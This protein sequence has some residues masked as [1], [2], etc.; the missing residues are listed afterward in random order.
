MGTPLIECYLEPVNINSTPEYDV[1]SSAWGNPRQPT[2]GDIDQ[3]GTMHQYPI[4]V[5]GRI[6][7]VPRN[8]YE[9]LKMAKEV[10]D[11]IERRDELGKTELIRAAQENRIGA[12]RECL[13]QNAWIHAQDNFGETA[14]HYAAENGLLNIVE[15]LLNHGASMGIVDS[16]GRTPLD[17]CSLWNHKQW[18]LAEEL[19][20]EWSKS[21][22]DRELVPA[23]ECIRVGR[24]IWID[25]VCVNQS[26]PDEQTSHSAMMAQIYGGAQSIVAWLGVSD[27][28][29]RIARKAITALIGNT[30]DDAMSEDDAWL[31]KSD[32]SRQDSV[33]FDLLERSW[34]ERPCLFQEVALGRAITAYCGSYKFRLADLL[35]F[36]RMQQLENIPS[37]LN[38][39]S[40]MEEDKGGQMRYE[41][42][43]RLKGAEPEAMRSQHGSTL[44]D[45]TPGN[46]ALPHNHLR[47]I[48]ASSLTLF[49]Q[50]QLD[51][52][53]TFG[54]EQSP[55]RFISPSGD[56]Y[57]PVDFPTRRSPHQSLGHLPERIRVRSSFESFDTFLYQRWQT[58]PLDCLF[59]RH[60]KLRL[61][62]V[63]EI[64]PNMLNHVVLPAH[65]AATIPKLCLGGLAFLVVQFLLSTLYYLLFH[66]LRKFPGPPL[67]RVSRLWS[68]IGNFKGRKS[69]RIHEAHLKYG[70][71]VRVGPNELSFAD[72][73]AVREIYN[74]DV[75]IKE[76]TFYRAKRIFHEDFL[77]SY[78]DP[79]AHKQRRKL[80]SRGFSQAAMLD[81]EPH[82]NTKITA[83]LDHWAETAAPDQAF[84]VY[85]WVH[86]LGF[87][88]VYHL[89]FDEDPGSVKYGR[90][91]EVMPYFRAW[92]PTYIYKEFMPI[93]E[94]WGVIVPGPVGN[95]FRG[96]AM[97]II[98]NC[99][100]SEVN[101][102]FLRQVLHGAKDGYLGRALTNSEI[103][104]EC[105]GGM[106][107]GSGTTANT[108]VYI[109]WGCLRKPEVAK[110]LREELVAAFPDRD[111]IPDHR[112]CSGLPLL[113]AVINETLRRYPTIIAT[114]PRAATKDAVVRGVAIP[115]GTIVGVQNYTM[116]RNE[117]A[118]PNSE[119]W[120][121]KRWLTK[122][123]EELR[124]EAW[125]PFSVGLRKC[126]GINLAQM[127]L[128]KITAAFFR[129]FEAS[130]DPSMR[131]ED[132]R[133][134][135]TFNASPAGAKLLLRLRELP[136]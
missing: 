49:G 117:T 9:A 115:K 29:T 7:F 77:L 100:V 125:V 87:D 113:Q 68:R 30:E 69:E 74:S 46:L 110:A 35:E 48:R 25:A 106:F 121:P 61:V 97:K 39:M 75:F 95:C 34:F 43:L 89:M 60:R 124:K 5:N 108:F 27:D 105:M 86:W 131:E 101:T 42:N 15:V 51:A 54:S 24:P 57:L 116:H 56:R 114:L 88:I 31:P 4:A 109:L 98:E 85:S 22:E 83:M 79:E 63:D 45:T 37:G 80:L 122:E 44:V 14:M 76:E 104:E 32:R 103:A 41:V 111:T 55:T 58:K 40:L 33:V 12:V 10:S 130:I 72:P 2:P 102:P 64:R 135:D 92:K 90:P 126:V 38:I 16:H 82:V 11:P 73:G 96:Y 107:G 129:R 133:M 127:E 17:C 71:I 123:G 20:Y 65:L 94:R 13:K 120:D 93:L 118:F 21:P 36:L 19:S 84:D 6:M 59:F 28:D 53:T 67:A 50:I 132:M 3:Y 99:R 8:I 81:F 70:P 62:V 134:F 78:R 26:N 23:L 128:N 136:S 52:V 18:N 119:E 91:H 47:P 1:I 66:P 112:T